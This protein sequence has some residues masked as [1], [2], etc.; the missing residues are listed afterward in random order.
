[1]FLSVGRYFVNKRT[2]LR[3]SLSITEQIVSSVAN[4]R[5]AL[6]IQ[7]Q[8]IYTKNGQSCFHK[9]YPTKTYQQC[10]LVSWKIII[11]C[12][13][14]QVNLRFTLFQQEGRRKHKKKHVFVLF[15]SFT[16]KHIELQSSNRKPSLP[17]IPFSFVAYPYTL[18]QGNIS[19]NSCII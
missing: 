4:Q 16:L 18:L 8:L 14:V 7:R 3:Y 19:L 17:K 1:M 11:W 15:L 10:R 2:L 12:G 5:T 9:S 13:L 6:Q